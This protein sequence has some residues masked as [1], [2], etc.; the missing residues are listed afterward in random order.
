[1]QAQTEKIPII[2]Y[3]S[4]HSRADNV[5]CSRVY[6]E[7]AR[8]PPPPPPRRPDVTV[9]PSVWPFFTYNLQAKLGVELVESTTV[10][11]S[12]RYWPGR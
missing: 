3:G 11:H 1:M 4:G 9:A 8:S 5:E 2:L 10:T 7:Q 12:S 6:F